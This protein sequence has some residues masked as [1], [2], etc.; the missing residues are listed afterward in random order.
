MR[1]SAALFCIQHACTHFSRLPSPQ[2]ALAYD[3]ATGL[4]LGPGI[5][6]LLDRL[7]AALPALGASASAA[8]AAISACLPTPSDA[9]DAGEEAAAD[10][11]LLPEP[12]ADKVRPGRWL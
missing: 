2:L 9:A 1:K 3:V 6:S 10:A 4:E 5:T 7:A 12:A 8:N 11:G